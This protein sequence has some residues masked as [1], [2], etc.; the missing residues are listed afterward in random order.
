M[1]NS[2]QW[3]FWRVQRRRADREDDVKM[4]SGKNDTARRVWHITVTQSLLPFKHFHCRFTA[5][6]HGCRFTQAILNIKFAHHPVT[7]LPRTGSGTGK[8]ALYSQ[9]SID[10][11]TLICHLVAWATV[12]WARDTL[13]LNTGL[14]WAVGG[15]L[16]VSVCHFQQ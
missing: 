7:Y 15:V 8:C 4:S 2:D 13:H 16:T 14:G 3:K 9:T 11:P 10:F 12:T 5:A 1:W 6:L